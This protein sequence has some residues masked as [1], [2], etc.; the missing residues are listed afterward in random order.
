MD[1]NRAVRGRLLAAGPDWHI[2]REVG[3]MSNARSPAS[4][5]HADG[6]WRPAVFWLGQVATLRC[7]LSAWLGA[8]AIGTG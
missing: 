1:H 4:D 5:L 3:L 8:G 7:R 6:S 2:M